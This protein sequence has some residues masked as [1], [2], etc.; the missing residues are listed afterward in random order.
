VVH[1]RDLVVAAERA[2]QLEEVS[3]DRIRYELTPR[4]KVAH[5]LKRW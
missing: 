5:L 3:P 2:E 1:P 4:G